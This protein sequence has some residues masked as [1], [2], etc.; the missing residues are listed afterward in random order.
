MQ[1]E[2]T[3]KVA[4]IYV[5]P[6]NASR[7]LVLHRAARTGYRLSIRDIGTKGF[8]TDLRLTQPTLSAAKDEAWHFAYSL[9]T[10]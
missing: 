7:E 1:L 8:G 6:L 5:A 4:G 3:R 9:V 2:F 10:L